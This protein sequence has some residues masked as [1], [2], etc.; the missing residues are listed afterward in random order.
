MEKKHFVSSQIIATKLFCVKGSD[1]LDQ[2]RFAVLESV[3]EQ[4]PSDQP[5][6]KENIR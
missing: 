2:T 1:F 6:P 5:I 3:R 4:I